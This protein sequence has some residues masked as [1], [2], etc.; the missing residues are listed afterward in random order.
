MGSA[1]MNRKYFFVNPGITSEDDF[2][3]NRRQG[4]QLFKISWL[5]GK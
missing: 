5:E 2:M 3:F 1:M 4:E